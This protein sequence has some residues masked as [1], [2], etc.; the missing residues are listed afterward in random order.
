MTF[1]EGDMKGLGKNTS[2]DQ[3]CAMEKNRFKVHGAKTVENLNEQ[4]NL[5]KNDTVP[6]K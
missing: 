2:S 1:L 4:K 3:R 6:N 5:K